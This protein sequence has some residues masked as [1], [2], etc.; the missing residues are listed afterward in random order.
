MPRKKVKKKENESRTP[1]IV[2]YINSHYKRYSLNLHL[3]TDKDIIEAIDR[4]IS[5]NSQASIKQLIRRAL[6]QDREY[7]RIS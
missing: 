3:E 2:N 1:Y 4:E 6:E 5:G 7:E